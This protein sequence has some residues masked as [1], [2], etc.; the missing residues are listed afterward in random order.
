MIPA[1]IP[2][3]RAL[4]DDIA[5]GTLPTFGLP[6]LICNAHD[7]TLS[8]ADGW[9]RVCRSAPAGRTSQRT[10]AVVLTFDETI[11][12]QQHPTAVLQKVCTA[13]SDGRLDDHALAIPCRA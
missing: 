11:R 12:R 5:A 8:T 6:I 7:C 2:T 9:L 1:G 13:R 10:P 4:H 3:K